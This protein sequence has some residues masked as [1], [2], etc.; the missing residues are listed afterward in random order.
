MC[1]ENTGRGSTHGITHNKNSKNE[2]HRR[3]LELQKEVEALR[4]ENGNLKNMIEEL[5]EQIKIVKEA[6]TNEDFEDMNK[7]NRIEKEINDL[8]EERRVMREEMNKMR[9]K[10]EEMANE[11]RTH[12]IGKENQIYI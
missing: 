4:K 12:N 6:Y 3:N 2:R 8:K 10:S 9:G 1:Q 5:T 11:R 7:F